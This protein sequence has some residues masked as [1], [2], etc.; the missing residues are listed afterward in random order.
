MKFSLIRSA[1]MLA[2]TLGL[3]SCGGGGDD[4]YTVAGSVAGLAY[5]GLVLTTNGSD[6]TVAPPTTAGAIVNFAFPNKLEY[7]DIYNVTVKA[8]PAHQNCQPHR[9]A[10]LSPSD[11]A[12]RLAAINVR[13]EC[14]INAYGIGGTVTGLTAADT[15]LVLA[16]GST[17]GTLSIK[18][19]AEDTTTTPLTY[20]LPAVQYDVSYGV[21][22]VKNPAGRICT[23]ANPTGIMR[24]DPITNI[25]VTC[26]AI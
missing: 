7:G 1:S 12:G 15:E 26:V 20:T 21:T 6:L 23:V 16:N 17:G 3:A 24:D 10:P 11:T 18:R 2:L 25:N 9:E 8:H 4:T 22:V 5:P 19:P 13:L 14:T